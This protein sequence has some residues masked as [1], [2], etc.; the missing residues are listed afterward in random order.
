M[1]SKAEFGGYQITRL[2]IEPTDRER[3]KRFLEDELSKKVENEVLIQF[4][5][6][7]IDAK[8]NC[9]DSRKRKG[10]NEMNST[11]AEVSKKLKS[12]P[13]LVKSA[14]SSRSVCRSVSQEVSSDVS[15][16]APVSHPV[17]RTA[18]GVWNS[19]PKRFLK[20]NTNNGTKPKV[21]CSV[22][23]T[24]E[25]SVLKW[26]KSAKTSTPVRAEHVCDL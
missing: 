7:N 11:A 22:K 21:K 14:Q 18:H 6:S 12:G 20:K 23:S 5:E 13:E 8:F 15:N 3:K 10:A 4:K 17:V 26:L 9:L 2:T 1:N 24:P 19:D 16:E 25:R